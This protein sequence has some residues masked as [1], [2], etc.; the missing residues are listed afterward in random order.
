MS[1]RVFFAIVTLLAAGLIALA[2][3]WPQGLGRPSPPPF[4]HPA[5]PEA[6]AP[7]PQSSPASPTTKGPAQHAVQAPR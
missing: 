2:L 3:V 1:D 6:A 7:R 5:R 4:G